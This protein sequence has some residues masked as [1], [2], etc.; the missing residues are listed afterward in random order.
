MEELTALERQQV[1]FS[2]ARQTCREAGTI[3]SGEDN[4]RFVL[5]AN[6]GD[7]LRRRWDLLR[8]QAGEL[9]EGFVWQDT[10]GGQWHLVEALHEHSHWRRNRTR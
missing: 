1:M 9:P 6:R 10:P 7:A 4:P 3:W 8:V 5:A 2:V